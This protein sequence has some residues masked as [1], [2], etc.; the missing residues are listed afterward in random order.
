MFEIMHSSV[1][2]SA[3]NDA[4][5]V[6]GRDKDHGHTRAPTLVCLPKRASRRW[7]FHAEALAHHKSIIAFVLVSFW[8]LGF[9]N[10][11]G[12]QLVRIGESLGVGT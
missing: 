12:F 5:L 2:R 3:T 1:L 7:E 11:R 9:E 6:L 10:N 4:C 8:F